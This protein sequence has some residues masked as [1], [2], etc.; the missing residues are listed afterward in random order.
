MK[1]VPI[2]KLAMA[3]FAWFVKTIVFFRSEIISKVDSAGA[4]DT[5]CELS[6]VIRGAFYTAGILM[7]A[8][9]GSTASAGRLLIDSLIIGIC[10]KILYLT[11]RAGDSLPPRPAPLQRPQSD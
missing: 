8:F 7:I 2:S 4:L 1:L 5:F 6:I 10:G 3:E 11:W 9:I